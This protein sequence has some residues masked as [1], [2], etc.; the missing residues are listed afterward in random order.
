MLISNIAPSHSLVSKC[1]KNELKLALV[2]L[3]A[4]KCV[5]FKYELMSGSARHTENHVI[6]HYLTESLPTLR[7]L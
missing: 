3:H 2:F 4:F 1:C 7:M 5:Y 6:V